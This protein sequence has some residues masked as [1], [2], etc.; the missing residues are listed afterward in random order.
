MITTD[1]DQVLK[2][3]AAE[4]S[5]ALASDALWLYSIDVKSVSP[6][7]VHLLATRLLHEPRSQYRALSMMYL[8]DAGFTGTGS[9]GEVTVDEAVTAR[10]AAIAAMR[11]RRLQR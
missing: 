3:N 6:F 5:A 8:K 2:D 9:F 1:E 11:L 10:N 7:L 4:L